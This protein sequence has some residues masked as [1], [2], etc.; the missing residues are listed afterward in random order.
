M[1]SMLRTLSIGNPTEHLIDKIRVASHFRT[2]GTPSLP[3]SPRDVFVQS[4]AGGVLV[5]WKLP[6]LHENIAGWRVYVNTESNL[7][8]QIRDK[9]TR[10]AFVP[11]GSS[12]TVP[13]VNVMISS[14]TTLG[15]ESAKVVQQGSPAPS[16]ATTIV[17]SVP[18]GYDVES[19]GGANRNLIEFNGSSQYLR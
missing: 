4:A 14:F 3:Q 1:K 2:R 10:Q 18:P 11:L 17:P 19:A 9:G 6:A 16:S 12:T 8:L 5:T 13:V 15:R 7:A